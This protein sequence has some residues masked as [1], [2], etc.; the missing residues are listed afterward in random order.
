MAHIVVPVFVKFIFYPL[1]KDPYFINI[2]FLKLS[3]VIIW[4]TFN[5]N[6]SQNP[7]FMIT[8]FEDTC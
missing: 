2:S 1:P 3:I 5:I 4:V 6:R 7:S 8:N